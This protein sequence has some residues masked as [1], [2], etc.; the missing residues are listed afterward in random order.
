MSVNRNVTVPLGNSAMLTLRCQ[1]VVGGTGYSVMIAAPSSPGRLTEHVHATGTLRLTRLPALCLTNGR[2][3]DVRF[4]F[5]KLSI[6]WSVGDEKGGATLDNSM[7]DA[8]C[9]PQ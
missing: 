6:I 5:S 1:Y 9:N 3:R 7:P 8:G 4:V 2:F